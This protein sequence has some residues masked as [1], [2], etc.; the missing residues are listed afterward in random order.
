MRLAVTP[1]TPHMPVPLLLVGLLGYLAFFT[2]VGSRSFE[3]RT[4]L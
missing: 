1:E 4:I 3:K 2:V